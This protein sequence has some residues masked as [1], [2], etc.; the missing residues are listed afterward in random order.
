MATTESVAFFRRVAKGDRRSGICVC[1]R[2]PFYAEEE[3]EEQA[4]VT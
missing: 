4:E 3:E 2:V 1:V